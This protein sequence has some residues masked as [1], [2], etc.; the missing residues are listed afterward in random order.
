MPDG[1]FGKVLFV[2]LS[3]GKIEEVVLPPAI[4]RETLGGTGLGVRVLY[5]R[6]R[7]GADPLGA[8]NVLGFVPGLL[9][10]T[11]VP[12]SGRFMVVGKS[13]LTGG[14]GEANCGGHFGPVLRA[15]GFD[16]L[17][18]TGISPLPVYLLLDGERAELR[19]AG[20]LWGLDTVETEQRI[21]EEVGPTA[22]VACIGPAGERKAL[23]AA[24]I[25]DSGRA[26]AR[27]GL[28]AVMGAKH[29]KAVV[30]RGT[31]RV[32]LH[33]PQ[34]LARLSGEYRQLF[35]AQPSRL[36]RVLFRMSR[37]F[38]PLMRRLR[39]KPSGGP[40]Q[41]I[42]GVYREYGTCSGT[43]LSTEIGDAPVQNWRGV[44]ARDFP[45]DRSARISDDAVI[46]H[47][48]KRYHCHNCPV[49]CGG[50]VRLGGNGS[51]SHPEEGHKPEYETLAAFGPLLLNDDLESIVQASNLC[52]RYGLDTISTG[53]AV[54]FVLE[55]AEQGLIG[56]E[57]AGGLDL[58]WG[59]AETIVELVRRIGRREGLGDLLADG[60]KRAAGR[61]GQ[62]AEAYAM[63]VGGQEL[64]MHDS[65]Y[66]PL[67]GLAYLVDPTPARH[68]PSISGMYGLESLREVLAAEGLTPPGRYEYEGKGALFALVNRYYQVV[69]AA[70]LCMFSLL[71]GRP[72]VREW[73]NAATGW[74][75]SLEEL[76]CIG[77]RIQVL[78]HAFNLREGV[79]TGDFSLPARV[80]GHPPLEAG[81]LKGVTLDVE[82][83]VRDYFRAM[84]FDEA[85][86]FPTRKLLESL[87]LSDVVADL[88][89]VK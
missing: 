83:M 5:E 43:A 41:A 87:G 7:P 66:E 44:G 47:Q 73:I 10:G 21:K 59:N 32:P 30:V 9:T 78:R 79:H 75:L 22:Q 68:T 56:R 85:T 84:G 20:H 18:V 23:I 8:Q 34:A 4:Y 12:F 25:T 61:I 14:W 19:E 17:F 28:G 53:A 13:P 76:L 49:G 82:A 36:P 52:N 64:P 42:I 46:Q 39:I 24:V 55:C 60:V 31:G 63:H 81:P 26:A 1:F 35:K 65:R 74:E 50:I 67:L 89:E 80:S 45:L 11:G 62:G 77:H 51:G 58:S 6:M 71:M 3:Q 48:V 40:T 88:E 72:P 29:L 69:S 2:D 33:D 37:V 57:E 86:G 38:A 70:G 16:G 27:S 54:A 15:T